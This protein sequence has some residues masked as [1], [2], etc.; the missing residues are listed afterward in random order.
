MLSKVKGFFK[1]NVKPITM[2]LSIA[3]TSV[4]SSISCFATGDTGT[5]VD[6]TSVLTTSVNDLKTELI[7][8]LAIIIPVAFGILIS[9]LAVKKV[10]GWV[11]GL[12][13][14]A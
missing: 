12:I 14:K 7:S 3:M 5:T 11:K 8:Y 10:F 1:R 2:S 9:Y 6:I 13:G 4:L